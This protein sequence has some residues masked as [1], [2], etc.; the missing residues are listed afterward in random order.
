[1]VRREERAMARRRRRGAASASGLPRARRPPRRR[2]RLRPAQARRARPRA[3]RDGRG[4]WRS[5]SP[6]P[7]SATARSTSWPSCSSSSPQE[8]ELTLLIVEH[9]MGLVMRVSD[10]VVVLDFGQV[11]A[12]GTP[13]RGPARRARDRGLPGSARRDRVLE[14]EGLHAGYGPVNVLEDVSF[15]VGEGETVALLGRQRR[16]QDDDAARDL[17]AWSSPRGRS[18]SAATTSPAARPSRS[19]GSASPT[20]PRAAARSRR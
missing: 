2:P 15:S 8:L 10:Q 14:V 18:R 11:I 6:P 1:M 20:C 9:H 16:R 3:V 17:R 12:A 19:S 4:C 5:T 13:A 7:A